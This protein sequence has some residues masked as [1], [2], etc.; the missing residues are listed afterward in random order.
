MK[1]LLI[2]LLAAGLCAAAPAEVKKSSSPKKTD[3]EKLF[4]N[5]KEQVAKGM[6]TVHVTS[7]KVYFEIPEKMFG[8]QMLLG[9]T[10]SA[11]SDNGDCL[12]GQKPQKPLHVQFTRRDSTV[13]LEQF[14]QRA[15]V[16]DKGYENIQEALKINKI[17]V[18]M[19]KFPVKAYAPG[20]SSVVVDVT[21][22]FLEDVKA[23][24]PFDHNG[25][26]EMGGMGTRS[27]KLQKDLCYLNGAKAFS[28]N[29]SVKSTLTYLSDVKLLGALSLL[30][31]QLMTATMTRTFLL[32]P[33]Q[34][35]K[36][37]LADSRLGI[38]FQGVEHYSADDDQVKALYYANRW[39]LQPSDEAAYRRG[40]LVEP[41][42]PIVFYVD[43]AFPATWLPA[44][45]QGIED[46]NLAFEKIGFKNA[47]RAADFPKDDPEFDPDNLKYSCVRYAPTW[48]T[49]AMGPSWKDPRT[50][51]ILTASVYIHHNVIKL[52]NNWRFVLT[53]QVDP[54][55]RR[56]SLPTPVLQE[57]L[58]YVT[59]H[60]V[61]HCL[62]LM[63]NMAASSAYPVD[64]LRSATFTKVHGTTPSI[65]D[66]ARFNY[67]AQPEDKGV[68]LTPPLIGKSDEYV[69]KW[70]YTPLFVSDKE[71]AEILNRWISEK[72]GDP[73]YR[74]GKQQVYTRMDPSSLEEDL[75]DDPIKAGEYGIRNLKYIM[76][77]L[78]EWFAAD[79]PDFAHRD[80][81]YTQ[82]MNQYRRYLNNVLMNIGGLY[83]YD[84]REGAPMQAYKP[85]P[86]ETQRK[87]LEF[88]FEQLQ[89][90]E[91]LKDKHL[92]RNL[93]PRL[94][95]VDELQFGSTSFFISMMSPAKRN[96]VLLASTYED[97]DKYTVEEYM[98]DLFGHV[99]EKTRQGKSLTEAERAYETQFVVSLLAGI[100]PS[101]K[102]GTVFF[103]DPQRRTEGTLNDFDRAYAPSLDE[104]LLYGLDPTGMA[105]KYQGLIRQAG[106]GEGPLWEEGGSVDAFAWQRA[107]KIDNTHNMKALNYKYLQ[108][109]E[110]LLRQRKNSGDE[111]TKAHYAHMLYK[112]EHLTK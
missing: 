12:V 103:T 66:Y 14:L 96:A 83:L 112:I 26:N 106:R 105:Q 29:V 82:I 50:G 57:A 6:F 65:M 62:G 110:K 8:R 22:L 86:K 30:N 53:A 74:Y 102:A 7:D 46:W 72:A 18:V 5:A 77:H 25:N 51:E 78:D 43:G 40:E 98:D 3:Y 71:E 58:R 68:R 32:L 97:G 2:V 44:I 4:G 80:M 64:S 19:Y 75:G 73:M 48:I 33:E 93:A 55:V 69:I 85:V 42:K 28:D 104:V 49:N 9:S 87:S 36:P 107:I 23:L 99:W 63:H 47:V 91:W 101:F 17:P 109:V 81:L 10:V 95:A 60:E 1:K 84:V 70:L 16:V 34:P 52:V 100:D 20:D 88:L 56:K 90:M 41:V 76:A 61:G 21:A 89:D 27:A 92:E 31:D 94:S 35:M 111:E 39:N 24:R 54:S 11:I 59:A 38:F 37:R 108:K 15:T 79:D 13:F 67:V 45:K